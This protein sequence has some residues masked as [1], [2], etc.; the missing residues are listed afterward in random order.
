MT[1]AKTGLTSNQKGLALENRTSKW[2]TSQFGYKCI[3]DSARGKVSHR[4]YDVDVHGV[5]GSIFKS[6][7]WVECKAFKI[8]RVNVTKLIECA[9][10]VKDLNNEGAGLQKWSPSMLMLV[11]SDGFDVDAIGMA[12]KYNI[13]CVHAKPT[14]FEFV[15]KR[16]RQHLEDGEESAV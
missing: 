7:L 13:Y 6:H 2:L 1:K 3:H 11:A 12:E 10:D 14:A 5:K 15:G 8:K 9:K 4:P 16:K